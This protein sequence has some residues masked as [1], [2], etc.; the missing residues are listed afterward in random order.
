MAS[1]VFSSLYTIPR[2][3]SVSNDLRENTLFINQER[4]VRKMG[5]P[6]FTSKKDYS[7]VENTEENSQSSQGAHFK[8]PPR[9]G[10][11]EPNIY[12]SHSKISVSCLR[13]FMEEQLK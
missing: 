6:S 5:E 4:I 3:T 13:R 1:N 8:F 7:Q 10:S 9:L 12:I 2:W 11:K